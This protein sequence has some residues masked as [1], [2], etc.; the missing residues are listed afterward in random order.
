[1]TI[2]FPEK[3]LYFMT[4]CVQGEPG[5]SGDPGPPGDEPDPPVVTLPSVT[6]VQGP[7]GERGGKGIK[8]FPGMPG[9]K[10]VSGDHVSTNYQMKLFEQTF[11]VK[12]HRV[13]AELCLVAGK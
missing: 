3:V 5:D 12:M 7:K 13:L 10:G 1:M 2:F 11:V 8:G 6:V 4:V 9:L